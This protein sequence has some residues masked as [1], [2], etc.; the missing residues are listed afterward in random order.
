MKI[1]AYDR[2]HRY[3]PS[4]DTRDAFGRSAQRYDHRADRANAP[5][6]E[7]LICYELAIFLEAAQARESEVLTRQPAVRSEEIR[8]GPRAAAHAGG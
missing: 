1:R 7:I 5:P 8:Q 2:Q 4:E 6:S 3:D